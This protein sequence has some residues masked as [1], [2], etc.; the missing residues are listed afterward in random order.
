MGHQYGRGQTQYLTLI[1]EYTS[2]N[3]FFF[4]EPVLSF[5][6]EWANGMLSFTHFYANVAAARKVSSHWSQKTITQAPFVD[7]HLLRKNQTFV[8]KS[9]FL[10]L[11]FG[12]LRCSMGMTK[13]ISNTQR[14]NVLLIGCIRQQ[15]CLFFAH[16]QKPKNCFLIASFV[17]R[18]LVFLLLRIL[19]GFLSK[20]G[21]VLL[22]AK[23]S[24]WIAISF[25]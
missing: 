20:K 23:S 14:H 1:R 11:F 4:S 19:T 13:D 7:G 12:Q 22:S 3:Q 9:S 18:F 8:T 6:K 21:T 10:D 2:R 24:R 5:P 15:F 25:P 17:A 16:A